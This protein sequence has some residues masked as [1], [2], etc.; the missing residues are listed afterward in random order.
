MRRYDENAAPDWIDDVGRD[1][2]C[3]FV[4]RS[5]GEAGEGSF[6]LRLSGV[7]IPTMSVFEWFDAHR[8]RFCLEFSDSSGTTEVLGEL[9]VAAML[10][11]ENLAIQKTF[12]C[13]VIQLT[14]YFV[15]KFVGLF[16][17]LR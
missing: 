17:D 4:L 13:H 1:V 9:P 7:I 11:R 16:V 12:A 8:G 6:V 14:I 3:V 15:L 5:T 10:E 2:G